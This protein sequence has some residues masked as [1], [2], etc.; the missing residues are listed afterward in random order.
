MLPLYKLGTNTQDHT[1]SI[2][3]P[4]EVWSALKEK[5]QKRRML[6]IAPYGK[7]STQATVWTTPLQHSEAWG[8]YRVLSTHHEY[9]YKEE[10]VRI[11][12]PLP[13]LRIHA[14]N[15][16]WL[17]GLSLIKSVREILT[18]ANKLPKKIR[19]QFAPPPIKITEIW[20]EIRPNGCALEGC[21]TH[22]DIQQRNDTTR[23]LAILDNKQINREMGEYIIRLHNRMSNGET[24][25]IAESVFSLFEG[26]SLTFPDNAQLVTP[27][28]Y[29]E[30]P[31]VYFE[32]SGF[33]LPHSALLALAA[34]GL[35]TPY[36]Q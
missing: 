5:L 22:P 3:L 18:T 36:Q 33:Y 6:V 12:C 11:D 14:R 21:F 7:S 28:F 20:S 13:Q 31:P 2:Y 29:A 19:E 4:R 30:K 24:N 10:Y 34:F 35:L 25:E 23:L 27:D 9:N 32:T 15:Y 16:R 17:E 26:F 8:Y 1:L